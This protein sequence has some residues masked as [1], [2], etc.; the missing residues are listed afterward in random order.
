MENLRLYENEGIGLRQRNT[1]YLGA[2]RAV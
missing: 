1:T 2:W